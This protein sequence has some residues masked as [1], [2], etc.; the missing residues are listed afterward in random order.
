MFEVFK[1]C[2]PIV[3]EAK[4]ASFRPVFPLQLLIFIG[5]FFTISVLQSIPLVVYGAFLGV[6]SVMQGDVQASSLMTT[7]ESHQPALV[8]LML[9]STG[10]MTILTIVYCRFQ[11]KRSLYSMGFTREKMLRD[12]GLGLVLGFVMFGA[13]VLIA[14]AGGTLKY[15]GYIIGNGWLML[16]AFFIGFV[17]QG[18]A[19]EVFLRGYLMISIASRNSIALAVFVNSIL[20]AL[21]HIFNSGISV[22][23][24]I[25]LA[26][27]GVFASLYTLKANSIWGISAIHSIWNFTQGNIFG[28]KVSGMDSPVS[29]FSFVPTGEGTLLNGGDFGLEG[30]LAVT[31]V[32]CISIIA[33]LLVKGRGVQP[34]QEPVEEAA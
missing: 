6:R 27:F 10:I 2:P 15:N 33:V 30:G 14:W 3:E 32:L 13:C 12:Y 34:I 17:I 25:N 18:M 22:L 26:L 20:F 7:M 11:E 8:L 24:V 28:I 4:K 16:F 9:F 19:E 5:V 1:N 29:L 21:L 23:A 31:I